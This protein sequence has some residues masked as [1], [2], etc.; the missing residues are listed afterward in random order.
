MEQSANASRLATLLD[1]SLRSIRNYVKEI[2]SAFPDTISSSNKGYSINHNKAISIL[3]EEQYDIPQTSKERIDFIITRLLNHNQR[4]R[5]NI[6]DLSNELYISTST[7]KNDL[8]KIKRK[9]AR[10]DLSLIQEGDWIHVEGLERNIRKILSFIL[11]EESSVNFVSMTSL[12][13]GFPD[14]DVEFIRKTLIE[15]LDKHQYFINDYS[16]INLLLHLTIAVDRIQNQSIHDEQ[17]SQSEKLFLNEYTVAQEILEKL[18]QKFQITYD[19]TEINEL[20]LLII[21]RATSLNYKKISKANIEQYIGK[22]LLAIVH[23]LINSINIFFHKN[24]F[25]EDFL[26][27]FALH[28]RNLLIRS[29][30]N[31][32]SKNP[33]ADS[34]RKTSPLIY[35]S[36][37]NL[38]SE[39]KNL[40]GISIND[41]EIAYIAFHIGSA[42]K[43]VESLKE[44][45][46]VVYYCPNYYD[47]QDQL[48]HF[49]KKYFDTDLIITSIISDE[50]QITELNHTDLILTSIPISTLSDI[51]VIQINIFPND[52]D[53]ILL[54]NTIL[55]LR[56]KKEQQQFKT[57]LNELLNEELFEV[58]PSIQDS[59][60]CIIYM[61]NRLS[62][63]DY[64]DQHFLNEVL[65]RE[66]LSHT[67]FSGAAIPHSMYMDAKKT[68]IS[69]LINPNG[70]KWGNTTVHIVLMMAF[71]KNERYIFNEIFEPLTM[72]LTGA[73]NLQNLTTVSTYEEFIEKIV[74]L[75]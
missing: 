35:E 69:I 13:Q 75:L 66:K 70:I 16:L 31:R 28:I 72:I 40:T 67:A 44:K 38:A 33:L 25:D 24:L 37:V 64:V 46:K 42:I 59:K 7:L 14:I 6:Y 43:T 41:D 55:K 62:D 11:Y 19:N 9:L 36:S 74:D 4:T 61:A 12:Q 71:K 50:S 45:I 51:P 15:I 30:N 68:A 52:N 3:K 8:N 34:I 57:Y 49:I 48:V 1:V 65:E 63:K 60:T 10:F 2:N 22:D 56:K 27:R 47:I 18:A 54:S 32:F 26:V 29:A 39:L 17:N 21:T 58:N 23:E 53:R 5:T 73:E 20:S